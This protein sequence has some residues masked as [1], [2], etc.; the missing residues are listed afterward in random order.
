LRD[1]TTIGWP[2]FSWIDDREK[3]YREWEMPWPFIV[4]ARGEGKTT[5]RFW[6]LFSRAHSPFLESNFYL[7]PLYKYKRI[8]SEPLDRERTRILFFLFSDTLS[9]NTETGASKR[10]TDFWPF[11]TRQRDL[12]GNTRL[13][14]LAPLEPYASGSHKIERDYSQVWSIWRAEKNARTGATSQSLL[15]NLYRRETNPTDKK[16]SLLFGLFQYQSNA[17]GKQVRLFYIPVGSKKA[18][19]HGTSNDH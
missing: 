8:R 2:F 14:I 18:K 15:W 19:N 3:K 13:Q 10:R 5:T 17:E 1:Q 12:N 16:G 6:P 11:F 9:K 7:W 4:V